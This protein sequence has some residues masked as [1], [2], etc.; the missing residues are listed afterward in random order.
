MPIKKFAILLSSVILAISLFFIINPQLSKADELDDINKQLSQLNDDLNKSIAATKPLEGQLT[1]MQKQIAS[2]KQQVVNAETGIVVKKRE[3]D[4]GYKRLSEK[5]KLIAQ[6]ISAYYINSYSDCPIC[7][8]FSL[9]NASDITLSLAYHRARTNQDK[10]VIVNLALSISD[11]ERKKANLEVQQKSLTLA[12]ASLDEQSKKLDSVVKGA[13]NF[14]GELSGKIAALSA[15]QQEILSAKS[16]NS[17]FTVGGGE[18]A[19]ELIASKKGFTESAPGGSFG[20]FSF[21]AYTHRKG[22]SQYGARGR[23]QAGQ[24]FKTI[25]KAY[26]GKDPVGKDTNGD[27]NVQGFGSMNFEDRYLMGI[28][29]MPS[30]WHPE[31]LKAQAVAART[32]AYRYKAEGKE[33]CTTEACQ[34]F[35]SGK[36]DNPPQAWKDAVQATKGQV[37]EDVVTYYASTH[38]GYASPIGWDTTDGSG[39]GNFIDKAWDKAGGSPWLYK[40]WWRQGYSNSSSTCGRSAPWLSSQEMA[41]IINATRFRDDRVTPV[42][43]SCWGGNPY[44]MDELRSKANGPSSV[45]G[46]TV[47]QGNGSSNE[48]VFQTNI[49]EIRL[50]ASAFK[51]AFNLRAPGYVRI[52]QTGF[53][54]FNIEHK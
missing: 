48:V 39:G 28:A 16:G 15:K 51:E 23:A 37:L 36:A 46:V 44:S 33:I 50:S 26:Y 9:G 30:S 54:F 18:S 14:Q 25:L 5:E 27:I 29:E 1:S 42:T 3:I 52:P 21:G 7:E 13:K 19:D 11:L 2:I 43:T 45:S 8:I 32:Y 31:A 34:V 22:M 17:T 41:D 53:A 49:G 24:D 38:G 20:V 10:Q 47:L 40:A 35:N 12:K 4:D 6:T